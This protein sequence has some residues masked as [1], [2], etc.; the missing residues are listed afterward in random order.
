MRGR[1][2]SLDDLSTDDTRAIRHVNKSVLDGII[3]LPERSDS[4]IEKLGD[5]IE[6]L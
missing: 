2:S 6:V 1:F 4:V 5:Y 3:M